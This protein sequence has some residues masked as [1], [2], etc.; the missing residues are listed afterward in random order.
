MWLM[1]RTWT[2]LL[3]VL[4]GSV[5]WHYALSAGQVAFVGIVACAFLLL[6][7]VHALVSIALWHLRRD[8]RLAPHRNDLRNALVMLCVSA[9]AI[10][11]LKELL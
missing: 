2:F 7:A 1:F 11:L 5:L 10:F 8:P 6:L 9:V 4:A 3:V